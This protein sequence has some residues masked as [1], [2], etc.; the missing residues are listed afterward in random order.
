MDTDA[1]ALAEAIDTALAKVTGLRLCDDDATRGR[2][3]NELHDALNIARQLVE[4][5]GNTDP[6]ESG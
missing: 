1:R 5:F 3:L 4:R 6:A 2:L